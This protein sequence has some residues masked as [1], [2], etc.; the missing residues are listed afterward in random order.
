MLPTKP[1]FFDKELENILRV[2]GKPF[3]KCVNPETEKEFR[4]GKIR[5]KHMDF[6]NFCKPKQ[7]WVIEYYQAPREINEVAWER[8]RY[9]DLEVR[10]QG[11]VKTDMLGEYPK[12]GRYRFF[13]DITDENGNPIPPN[14]AVIDKIKRQ[15]SEFMARSE[16]WE[17]ETPEQGEKKILEFTDEMERERAKKHAEDF[18][19]YQGI[20]AKR[21]WDAVIS[22]PL[23]TTNPK[24]GKIITEI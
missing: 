14:Q 22:K 17:K 11:L 7:C 18:F 1:S 23:I 21:A 6:Q 20:S 16:E 19:Q 15:V 10:G 12:N 5:L 9:R 24:A 2:D 3:F 13:M 8:L 4:A